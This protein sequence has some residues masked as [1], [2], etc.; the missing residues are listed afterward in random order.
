MKS[1][2][3]YVKEY[4]KQL[5]IGDI[6][7]AYK[8]IMDYM[9]SLKNYFSKKY[10]DFFISGNIYY[11]YMDMTYLSFTPEVLKEKKLKI[12]IV[13]IH[14]KIRFEVW[15]AG[16]NKAIQKKYWKLI[17]YTKWD[18]YCIPATVEG[19]D[20]IIEHVLVEDPNFN[21]LD[22]LTKQIEAGVEEFINNI[23]ALLL[24][25]LHD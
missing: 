11:G 18:K 22:D 5:E 2:N 12:A 6:K 24:H 14:E 21:D 25:I 15:L 16:N 1:L 19:K 7:Y 17:N 4:Q 3:D 10:P 20:A 13:F 8:G 23:Q 9:M